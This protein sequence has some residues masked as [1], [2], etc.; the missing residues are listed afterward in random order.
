[1]LEKVL[2]RP[3]QVDVEENLSTI[4]RKLD[5]SMIEEEGRAVDM[6]KNRMA[7]G[8]DTIIA[9][10]IKSEGKDLIR[11]LKLLV[12]TIWK[13]GK[14]PIRWHMSGLFPIHRKEDTSICQNYRG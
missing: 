14:I 11:Q 7:S 2:N 3:F 10:F 13:Q 6:L 1:M 5:D 4:E 12:G 8:E 9:E